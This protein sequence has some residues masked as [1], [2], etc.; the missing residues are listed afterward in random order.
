[1]KTRTLTLVALFMAATTLAPAHAASKTRVSVESM[2]VDG[3]EVRGLS[4]DL[5]DGGM[6]AVMAVVGAL[7]KKKKA[8]DACAP[9]GAAFRVTWAWAGG[10]TAD[11]AVA[12][13]SLPKKDACVTAA[14]KQASSGPEGTCE[15]VVL[16]GAAEAAR[17]AADG[18]TAK[19]AEAPPAPAAPAA[20]HSN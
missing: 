1:M 17:K 12:A 6:F 5:D 10:K 13:S 18:L 7:A 20:P 2:T 9:G 16:V 19:P 11:A 15:A 14:L 3:Q 4:C 8:L